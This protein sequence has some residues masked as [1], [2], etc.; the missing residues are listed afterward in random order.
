M[1]ANLVPLADHVPGEVSRHSK[2]GEGSHQ[3][4]DNPDVMP[5]AFTATGL[6]F[7]SK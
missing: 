6:K 7:K 4:G 3:V 5:Q 1:L 2:V